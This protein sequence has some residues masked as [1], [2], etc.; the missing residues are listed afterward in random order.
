ML[1]LSFRLAAPLQIRAPHVPD[2]EDYEMVW[3]VGQTAP[4][5]KA[6]VVKPAFGAS[7]R[8]KPPA[9]PGAPPTSGFQASDGE[10]YTNGV[11]PRP[12]FNTSA[13]LAIQEEEDVTEIPGYYGKASAQESEAV[14][15][16]GEPDPRVLS[17]APPVA[18]RGIANFRVAL[19]TPHPPMSVVGFSGG[20]NWRLPAARVGVIRGV[21]CAMYQTEP[22]QDP[23]AQDCGQPQRHLLHSWC[24]AAVL[25]PW[26]TGRR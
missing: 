21:I 23:P 8:K 6:T 12:G 9:K 17:P 18:A 1:P 3:P 13:P 10:Y 20:R 24:K 19:A 5:R 15:K 11:T 2:A 7:M 26:E 22:D 14:L 4:A 16:V 25:D